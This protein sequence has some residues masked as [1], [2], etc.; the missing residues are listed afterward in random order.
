MSPVL[1][2]VVLLLLAAVG[3]GLLVWFC[4]WGTRR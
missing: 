2:S 1:G 3:F 4:H